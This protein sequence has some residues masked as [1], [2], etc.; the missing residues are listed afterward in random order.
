MRGEFAFEFFHR[1]GEEIAPQPTAHKVRGVTA[2]FLAVFPGVLGGLL[3]AAKGEGGLFVFDILVGGKKLVDGGQGGFAGLGEAGEVMDHLAHGAFAV[4]GLGL[5]ASQF[6][7][8]FLGGLRLGLEDHFFGGA[9]DHLHAA[10]FLL[11][12]LKLFA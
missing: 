7:D 6:S 2:W 5:N 10:G 12:G 8:D 4:V 9:F 3:L 1:A 11:S